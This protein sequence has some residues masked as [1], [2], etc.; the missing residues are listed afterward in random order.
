MGKEK[1][2][3]QA[4][5]RRAAKKAVKVEEKNKLK[6]MLVEDWICGEPSC[7]NSNY[8][9][10]AVC[11]LCGVPNPL[12]ALK[13][14]V[15]KKARPVKATSWDKNPT[16]ADKARNLELRDMLEK[17]KSTGSV[18]TE[19]SGDDRSRAE[20]LWKRLL[21]KRQIK[22]GRKKRLQKKLGTNGSEHS[23]SAQEEDSDGDDDENKLMEKKSK[24][25]TKNKKEKKEK[26]EKKA[27][28]EREEEFVVEQ[29]EAVAAVDDDHS[30]SD[31]DSVGDKKKKSKKD[32]KDKKD[33]KEKKEKKPI[34]ENGY[35][36]SNSVSS[37]GKQKK[38]K[39][40]KEKS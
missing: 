16:D 24:K 15:S 27:K 36:S 19:L 39:S 8:G 32:K 12:R 31:S 26:K 10:R 21:R 22:Q 18:C 11:N 29:P 23:M 6:H 35:D 13:P 40:K 3:Q 17:E 28:K 5:E 38:K 30:H 9:R 2:S 20:V 7:G 1:R 33:K 25:D 14:I 37:S 4:L 34:E